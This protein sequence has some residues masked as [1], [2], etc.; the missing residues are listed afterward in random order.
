MDLRD[1]LA[2]GV[3]LGLAHGRGE[4]VDLAVDIRFG[5]LVQVDQRD[6]IDAA[7][8]Q[9]LGGPGADAAN[10]DDGDMRIADA[11]RAIHAIKTLQPAKAALEVGFGQQ[12][13]GR[14]ARR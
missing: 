11:G 6:A 7:A 1:A 14:C 10:A 3:H 4:G 12:V 2:H 9:G 5:D 8:C 13:A